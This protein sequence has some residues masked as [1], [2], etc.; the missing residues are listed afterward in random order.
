MTAVLLPGLGCPTTTIF[1]EIKKWTS[2]VCIIDYE[3]LSIKTITKQ[4][5]DVIDSIDKP[6]IVGHSFGGII[7]L[8][9]AA[10][11]GVGL[12]S[13][14]GKLDGTPSNAT[15]Q[16]ASGIPAS[17]VKTS[18][19][20][21]KLL[22]EYDQSKLMA[23]AQSLV[24]W[25]NAHSAWDEFHRLPGQKAYI[26]GEQSNITALPNC[27]TRCINDAGHFPMLDNPF[28]FYSTLNEVISQLHSQ[29][30][31]LLEDE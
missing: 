18:P 6:I 5:F 12:V 31:A 26:Y 11:T 2:D 19:Q 27:E 4:V 10:K 23:H 8:L 13:I 3:G 29:R 30:V 9:V 17:L 21:K 7:G 22:L 20:W 1:A 16:L 14:E 25:L 28:T 24:A 15:Y